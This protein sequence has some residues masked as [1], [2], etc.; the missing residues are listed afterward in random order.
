MQY[1]PWVGR[2]ILMSVG[3]KRARAVHSGQGGYTLR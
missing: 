1:C 2:K 3:P